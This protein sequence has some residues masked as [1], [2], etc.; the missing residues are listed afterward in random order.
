MQMHLVSAHK[1]FVDHGHRDGRDIQQCAES[2]PGND[3]IA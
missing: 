3:Y 2:R 1:Q